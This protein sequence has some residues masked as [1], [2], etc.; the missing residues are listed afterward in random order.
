MSITELNIKEKERTVLP[1]ELQ[2]ACDFKPGYER[3]KNSK[4]LGKGY[5]FKFITFAYSMLL[6]SLR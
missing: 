2:K 5:L 3:E 4:S 1:V 6:R